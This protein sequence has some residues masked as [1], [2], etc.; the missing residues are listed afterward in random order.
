MKFVACHIT[1]LFFRI[2][3]ITDLET[4]NRRNYGKNLLILVGCLNGVLWRKVSLGT[5]SAN[6]LTLLHELHSSENQFPK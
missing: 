2:I 3:L 6:L 5:C 4:Q 1:M